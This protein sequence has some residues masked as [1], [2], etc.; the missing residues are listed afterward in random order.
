[1]WSTL[2]CWSQVIFEGPFLSFCSFFLC[3]VRFLSRNGNAAVCRSKPFTSAG[4]SHMQ[5]TKHTL[6]INN[7]V[8]ILHFILS[9]HTEWESR[10]FEKERPSR[11]RKLKGRCNAIWLFDLYNHCCRI[12][13][14][15]SRNDATFW[16]YFS[17]ANIVLTMILMKISLT[18]CQRMG[19][20][21][22]SCAICEWIHLGMNCSGL[23]VSST[24]LAHV[25][26]PLQ[27]FAL[28]NNLCWIQW[29]APLSYFDLVLELVH[30]S[31]YL[32]E[33]R[34]IA[35]LYGSSIIQTRRS[36]FA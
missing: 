16:R 10:P 4:T 2:Y 34:G 31:Q 30:A 25:K 15:F 21:E 12:V 7:R 22:I 1:M 20:E 35:G 23:K 3:V 9:I 32:T 29:M 26:V 28:Y 24:H 6:S 11:A 18:Y 33:C 17:T 13:R 5:Q 27:S 19:W 8:Y 36:G 14:A